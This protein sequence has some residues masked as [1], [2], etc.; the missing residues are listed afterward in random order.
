MTRGDNMEEKD[1]IL[2]QLGEIEDEVY[3]IQFSLTTM[4]KSIKEIDEDIDDNFSD[5]KYKK[6]QLEDEIENLRKRIAKAIQYLDDNMIYQ[7]Y[8]EEL[9]DILSGK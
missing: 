4:L 5:F 9:K 2:Y 3:D 7:K 8:Y 1:N 6:E